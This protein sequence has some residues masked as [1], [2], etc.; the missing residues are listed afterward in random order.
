MTLDSTIALITVQEV[1]DFLGIP[2]ENQDEREKT[3][4]EGLINS[5]SQAIIN[6]CQR[7][8]IK[9]AAAISEIKNGDNTK[10]IYVQNRPIVSVS[11][12]KY[13]D[14]SAYVA[15]TGTY[16]YDANMGKIWFTDGNIFSEYED[17]WQINYIYG[18][19]CDDVPS[20][21]KLACIQMVALKKKLFDDNAH[22]VS[23]RTFPD[24]NISYSF[25][26]MPD[27]VKQTLNFYR[28]IA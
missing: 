19:E 6:Y 4:I 16:S 24:Q 1:N 28:K 25:D 5:A 22:G 3:I 27:D 12:I 20:D 23:S 7:K 15:H 9:V 21:L 13:W 17:Y 14:G 18:Y 11:S 2:A 10:C 26:K 8:F